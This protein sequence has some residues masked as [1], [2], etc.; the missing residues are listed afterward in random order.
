[1]R[2]LFWILGAIA[3]AAGGAYAISRHTD[4][5]I[6]ERFLAAL[7][8][9]TFVI[10]AY[11]P[12]IPASGFRAKA[13]RGQAGGAPFVF[14]GRADAGGT[15]W[16]YALIWGGFRLDLSWNSLSG[17]AEHPLQQ[18]YILLLRRASKDDGLS[19]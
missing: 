8:E 2:A 18:A 4:R 7:M 12:S 5:R 10:H 16:S 19:N 11:E 17:E 6:S 14:V 13:F 3:A 9:D 1:M 15:N